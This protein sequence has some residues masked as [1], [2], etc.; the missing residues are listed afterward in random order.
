MRCSQRSKGSAARGG[1]DFR[2]E[3]LRRGRG[4]Q[5]IH[6]LTDAESGYRLIHAV[7]RCSIACRTAPSERAAIHGFALARMEL[8]LACRYRVASPT[9]AVAR[10]PEVL[11]GI[12]P[13]RRHGADRACGRGSP[14]MELMLSVQARRAEKALRLGLI[15]RLVPEAELRSRRARCCSRHPRHAGPVAGR[16]LSSALL[17]PLVRPWLTR[18]VARRAPREHYRPLRHH[19]TCG[20]GSAHTD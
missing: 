7:K 9:A 13:G 4:Y 20:R 5:G 17:R 19:L 10:L 12:H 14:A 6:W 2:R 16:L 3:R 8:A 15:D 11:L 1:G 18:K